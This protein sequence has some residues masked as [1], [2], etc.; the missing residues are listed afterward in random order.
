MA[1]AMGIL[2]MAIGMYT[3]VL[4]VVKALVWVY[5]EDKPHD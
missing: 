1:K 2:F 5:R 4:W 3:V